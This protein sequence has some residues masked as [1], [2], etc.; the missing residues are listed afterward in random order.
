MMALSDYHDDAELILTGLDG[1][2]PLAFLAAL[3]TL[4]ALTVAWPDRAIKMRWGRYTGAW[5]PVIC[6]N[7]VLEEE[8]LVI[9]LD[10]YLKLMRGHPALG[11]ADDLRLSPEEFRDFAS[12][13]IA[14]AHQGCGPQDRTEADFAAAF[15]CDA[16]TDVKKNIVRDTALRTVGG[17]QQRFLAF[18]RNIVEHTTKGHLQK[19]LFAA[20]TYDDPVVNQT[21]RW[22][23]VDDSRYALR[24]NDPSGDPI[25]KQRGGML[26]ANRLAIE[27]LPMVTCAPV[28]STLGTV[29]FSGSGAR[30]TFWTW[31]I[32]NHSISHDVCRSLLA[33]P[34]LVAEPTPEEQL[35][36][37]GITTA[38]RSQRIT[39]EKYRNF[40]P[41]TPIF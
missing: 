4:R 30:N 3:G 19:T 6:A 34:L 14:A 11:F 22:D 28:G 5:R 16:V 25:R 40:A 18:M 7:E 20:W 41:A 24:W 33:I 23:P 38:F 27:G 17:G 9:T 35:R 29:G 1:S 39:V 37:I 10:T 32:W 15:A 13:A 2:N 26:G 31:P 8:T 36:A 12:S 21:L